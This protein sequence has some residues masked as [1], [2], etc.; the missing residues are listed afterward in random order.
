HVKKR[1]NP[2]DLRQHHISFQWHEPIKART[3][4]CK[5]DPE[6][7]RTTP[8]EHLFSMNQSKE[9]KPKPL[10]REDAQKT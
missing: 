8:A 6:I 3:P 7:Q 9:M 1:K 10:R 4:R 5:D 2:R